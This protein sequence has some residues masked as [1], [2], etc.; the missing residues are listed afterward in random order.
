MRARR[1]IAGRF[2]GESTGELAAVGMPPIPGGSLW[3]GLKV[4]LLGGS[5]NPAHG[6]HLQ[7]SLEAIKRLGLDEVWWLVSP[8]NPL[9]S[10]REMAPLEERLA[11]ARDMARHPRIRVSA[12][13]DRLGTRH[14]ATTLARLKQALPRT[15]FVWII[16]ADNLVQLPSWHRWQAIVDSVPLAIMDRN[17]YSLKGLNGKLA[18]RY[19]DNR[20]SDSALKA[21]ALT[22]PP[23]WAFVTFPRH[24]ASATELRT[25]RDRRANR[26]RHCGANKEE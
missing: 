16:G 17:H 13:E 15:Y 7:I 22:P 8:Q 18:T 11:T 9:K 4:G 26:Q 20:M 24:P 10:P 3:R 21:L 23:A 5:F 1:L 2:P 25:R 12:L 14:T 19:T 6:G